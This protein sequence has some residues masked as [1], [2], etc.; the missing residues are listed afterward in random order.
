MN[1]VLFDLYEAQPYGTSKFHGGGEYIKAVFK[2]LVENYSDKA[3]IYVYYNF[4]S[5]LDT[6]ILELIKKY[7]IQAFDIKKRLDVKN[8]I[9]DKNIDIWYSGIPYHYEKS[10]VG[11][12]A[13]LKGTIHG[14]RSIE[15]P[16]DR[17]AYLYS[18]GRQSIKE[19]IKY[20]VRGTYKKRE[21]KKISACI[22]MLDELICDSEHSKYS[23]IQK[24]PELNDKKVNVYYAPQKI[25]ELSQTDVMGKPYI[26]LLGGDRWVKNTYRAMLALD[27]L[28]NA[29][30][31]EN[32]DVYIVGNIN[33]KIRNRIKNNLHFKELGYVDTERLE[34][35]YR[36]CK[37]FLYPSLN[38]GFGLPPLEAM[39]YGKTCIVSGICSLP[40]ICG[41]AAYY[42]NPVDCDEI[43]T[44]ILCAL[45]Q[46]INPELAILQ[47]KKILNRESR[48][49]DKLCQFI[50][51]KRGE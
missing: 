11:N 34:E 51:T 22:K 14:L 38:E 7:S 44:R 35:L 3:C 21:I 32:Y 30:L 5:F 29:N 4:N 17:W 9:E 31:I 23:L 19:Q 26:L 42:V 25:S 28:Y 37:L 13:V 27:M 10:D 2:Y 40:E 49:I 41:E 6:W 16:G 18:N 20:I 47:F 24:Y 46:P 8:I 45:D 43:A 1:S 15:M 36:N 48:D 33:I 39:K 50:I 12:S